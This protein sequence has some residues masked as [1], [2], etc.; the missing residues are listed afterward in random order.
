[1]LAREEKLGVEDG[2]KESGRQGM[3]GMQATAWM[4]KG[5]AR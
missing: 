2:G 3:Q 1:L 4:P 5:E